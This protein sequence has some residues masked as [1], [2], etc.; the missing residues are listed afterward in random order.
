[1]QHPFQFHRDAS[2]AGSAEARHP[3]A[4]SPLTEQPL[5]VLTA[6]DAV[7]GGVDIWNFLRHL[8]PQK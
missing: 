5:L 3:D 6:K 4:D 8:G 2:L 1:V 7:E